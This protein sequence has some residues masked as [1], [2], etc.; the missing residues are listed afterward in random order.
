LEEAR[1]QDEVSFI[2]EDKTRPHK[3]HLKAAVFRAL[4]GWYLRG[5]FKTHS[6]RFAPFLFYRFYKAKHQAS[7]ELMKK[8]AKVTHP[9]NND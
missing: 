3:L 6:D 7:T 9:N 8:A 1:L 2:V 5:P 4:T